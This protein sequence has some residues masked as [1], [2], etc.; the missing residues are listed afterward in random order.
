MV[1]GCCWELPEALA[2]QVC[3]F[4]IGKEMAVVSVASKWLR[5]ACLATAKRIVSSRSNKSRR[6]EGGEDVLWALHCVERY[7]FCFDPFSDDG[8][9][10]MPRSGEWFLE[11][12]DLALRWGSSSDGESAFC[13]YGPRSTA[14]IGL[15]HRSESLKTLDTCVV[16]TKAHVLALF[17]EENG[18]RPLVV[19]SKKPSDARGRGGPR[20]SER[21]SF[22]GPAQRW[23]SLFKLGD[24]ID[25]LREV[26]SRV[27]EFNYRRQ[28]DDDA[29]TIFAAFADD[30]PRPE[31][32][33]PIAVSSV[34]RTLDR[35]SLLIF[36]HH[37]FKQMR[38]ILGDDRFNRLGIPDDMS[39]YFGGDGTSPALILVPFHDVTP[40]PLRIFGYQVAGVERLLSLSR[41]RRFF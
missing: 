3:E 19:C 10:A 2:L 13:A 16:L 18:P 26:V 32:Q 14:R 12:E 5:E 38:R 22:F 7:S 33:A 29:T 4:L 40:P 36:T 39:I 6:E 9:V 11:E 41:S 35:N 20:Q 1:L 31:T 23:L 27:P 37:Q 15:P 34:E 28:Q 17:K 21:A 25:K 30:A 8:F 24:F